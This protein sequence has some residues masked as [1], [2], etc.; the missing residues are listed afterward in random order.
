[1][2]ELPEVE[3][4]LR[5]LRARALGR[6]IAAV[7]VLHPAVIVG[8]RE[9]F[10]GSVKGRTIEAVARKGKVL[11]LT[12]ADQ[13]AGPPCYLLLRLGM[14]GQFVVAPR[15]APLQP[16]T[17]LRLVLDDGRKELRY[18]DV[19]RFG[20]FRCCTAEEL[21]AVFGDLGPDAREISEAQFLA[22]LEGRRGPIKSWLLNQQ[23]LSGVGNIYADEALFDAR[24]HPLTPAGRLSR[25]AARRLHRAMKKVLDRAVALQGTSFRDYI[26]IEGRPGSYRTRLRVYQRTGEP[27]RRCRT[28][29]RRL[30]IAGRSSHFCPRCQPRPRRVAKMRGPRSSA[31]ARDARARKHD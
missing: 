15:A 6:R 13:A 14:T 12:L 20:R 21:Q 11:A 31:P 4:V 17:H 5:G 16:H 29:I 23:F 7:E 24:L 3:T 27:C 18:R 19:R 9:E 22:A 28:P 8:S 30:V 26:D 1:M 2:P 10:A 25:Q